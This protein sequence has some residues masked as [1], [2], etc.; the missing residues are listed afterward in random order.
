MFT[1][2]MK[3]GDRVYFVNVHVCRDR[4]FQVKQFV[5]GDISRRT[6]TYVRIDAMY[7]STNPF[8]SVGAV[9]HATCANIFSLTQSANICQKLTLHDPAPLPILWTNWCNPYKYK[10]ASSCGEYLRRVLINKDMYLQ[11]I[12]CH[13][14]SS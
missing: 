3:T 2:W 10:R 1:I 8:E 9:L 12:L 4:R 6:H 14:I 7:D 5:S 11:W 13:V